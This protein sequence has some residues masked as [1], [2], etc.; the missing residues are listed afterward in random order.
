ML[1][2]F[3]LRLGCG[4]V[5]SLLLLSPRQINP[6]FYRTHFLTVLGLTVVA[7]VFLREIADLETWI[8]LGAG[9][10][11]AFI[12][13]V[14]WSLEK[15]PGGKTFIV[16]DSVCLL[17]AVVKIATLTACGN[18]RGWNI[19]NELTSAALL[20][21]A[22]TAMLVGHSYLIAPGMSL[23]PLMRSLAGVAVALVAR[24]VIGGVGLWTSGVVLS[25]LSDET[26]L[27]PVRWGMGIVL[28]LVLAVM[29]WRTARIR[30]T[31]SAT[32]I[33]YVVVIFCFVGELMSQLLYQWTTGRIL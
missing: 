7:A 18:S 14:A 16:L 30:S 6:R 29:A 2:D 9:M 28:P 1:G 8:W 21:T 24:A 25:K 27:L 22:T 31:Q 11:F 15:S 5:C 13:A 17:L 19:A 20:G 26:V 4:L 32:G 12:G 33:L 23:A 10:T 3:C